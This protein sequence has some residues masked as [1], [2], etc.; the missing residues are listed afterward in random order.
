M[1]EEVMTLDDV[2]RGELDGG[3]IRVP[4]WAWLMVA[5]ALLAVYAVTMENGATLAR[6]ARVLHEFFHDGRHFFGVPC[7]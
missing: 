7:H 4:V 3:A 5:V 6:G 2:Y 1:R